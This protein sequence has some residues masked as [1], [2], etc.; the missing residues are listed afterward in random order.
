MNGVSFGIIILTLA[1]GVIA[2]FAF[3]EKEH[4]TK[5]DS[6]PEPKT[7]NEKKEA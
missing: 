6:Q 5:E 7:G 1:G 4:A 3:P 2:S